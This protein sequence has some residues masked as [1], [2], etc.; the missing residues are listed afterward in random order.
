LAD[1]GV[2]LDGT[3]LIAGCRHPCSTDPSS[4]VVRQRHLPDIIMLSGRPVALFLAASL[5][6]VA[7]ELAAPAPA[8]AECT[9]SEPWPSFRQVAPS[10]DRIIVG[11]VTWNPGGR[12]NNRFTL[13]VDEVLRG[14]APESIEFKAFVSGM[15]VVRCD[16]GALRVRKRVGQRMAIAYGGHVP[17]VKGPINTV[18][19][20][21][22]SRPT[23]INPNLERLTIEEVRQIARMPATDTA[24]PTA[25]G[26]PAASA[27]MLALPW[28]LGA[29]TL[30]WMIALGPVR[31][32][33]VP[34]A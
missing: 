12:F 9:V 20:I 28:I 16:D 27:P 19:F 8:R 31:R 23:F 1:R 24:A 15:P 30:A 26:T 14:K 4:W 11:T 34:H 21:K 10:A 22:P 3:W 7:L 5:V 6:G 25:G 13:N 2:G 17:S 29:I 33:R 32:R 18:A